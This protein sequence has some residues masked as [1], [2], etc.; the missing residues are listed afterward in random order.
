MR[1]AIGFT[2]IELMAAVVI[3][4]VLVALAIPRYRVFV[5]RSRQ[6]EAAINLGLIAKLQQSYYL[7]YSNYN[8]GLSIGKG[9]GGSCP[10]AADPAN[11]LGFR[12]AKCDKLRYTY[13]SDSAGGGKA[14]NNGGDTSLLIYPGCSGA[15]KEDEWAIN[16]EHDLTN[17][18]D[19]IK[20]CQE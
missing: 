16:D 2:L 8:S 20:K 7:R 18:K 19:I 5:A 15:G 10:A 4:G 3:V 9:G 13:T 17:P 14:V 6:S 11:E 12:T 1:N